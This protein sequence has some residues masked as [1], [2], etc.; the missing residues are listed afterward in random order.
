VITKEEDLNPRVEEFLKQRAARLGKTPEAVRQSLDA[1]ARSISVW[2]SEAVDRGIS[3]HKLLDER[4]Q[5]KSGSAYPTPLCITPAEAADHVDPRALS[6]ER[7]RHIAECRGC[8]NLLSM[9]ERVQP[10]ERP[11]EDDPEDALHR[12]LKHLIRSAS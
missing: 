1:E 3:V 11:T 8:T 10:L 7:T 2:R 12:D 6:S 9:L 5:D 4:I